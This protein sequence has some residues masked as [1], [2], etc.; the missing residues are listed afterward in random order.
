MEKLELDMLGVYAYADA[1]HARE[2]ELWRGF[3]SYALP[4]VMAY[5]AEAIDRCLSE[6][7]VY[8]VAELTAQ[9][10]SDVDTRDSMRCI[11]ALLAKE[12]GV[13]PEFA[14][15]SFFEGEVPTKL[16]K[17]KSQVKIKGKKAKE[18][19]SE[20]AIIASWL[21]HLSRLQSD[22]KFLNQVERWKTWL[23]PV[24][25]NRAS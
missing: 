20:D 8:K 11:S 6:S 16:Y 18:S 3:L 10:G 22:N 9:G 25:K 14:L 19:K 12:I 21:A 2:R 5:S 24:Q 13:S 4:A 1:S 17:I 7:I 23:Y 15:A